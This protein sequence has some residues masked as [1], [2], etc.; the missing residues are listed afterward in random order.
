MK[1]TVLLLL[2]GG[3]ILQGLEAQHDNQEFSKDSISRKVFSYVKSFNKRESFPYYGVFNGP[4]YIGPVGSDFFEFRDLA[5]ID[6]LKHIIKHP[7]PI[8]K[9]YAF[10][11]LTHKGGVDLLPIIHEYLMD[12]THL[13][14]YYQIN[15]YVDRDYL[16]C[17]FFIE[18]ATLYNPDLTTEKRQVYDEALVSFDF[19]YSGLSKDQLKELDS[20]LIFTPNQLA[21]SQQAFI[22]LEA[23][24]DFY[25]QLKIK[26][27]TDS[28]KQALVAIAKFRKQQDIK[29][30]QEEPNPLIKLSAIQAFP[31]T[32]FIPYLEQYGRS[33]PE[34]KDV[35]SADHIY[36]QTLT[37][38]EDDRILELLQELM[39]NNS[40]WSHKR[41][42]YSF[43]SKS[44]NLSYADLYLAFYQ[45][46][47][48][49]NIDVFVF[50]CQNG[51]MDCRQK[52]KT[53]LWDAGNTYHE[54]DIAKTNHEFP[55]SC[56]RDND[57]EIHI[58]TEL[59]LAI[60][61]TIGKEVVLNNLTVGSSS[62]FE[63]F[64]QMAARIKDPDMA[65]I[66][67]TRMSHSDN[68][69][70][71]DDCL[72]A[73]LQFGMEE[74]S[75]QTISIIRKKKEQLKEWELKR[76]RATFRK[77]NIVWE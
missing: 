39:S 37:L 6:E 30:I 60:D 62:V 71:M 28:I 38:Y 52:L 75:Q 41:T 33:I 4:G 74:I 27:Q 35:T 68:G 58:L 46:F 36:Y 9:A 32:F 22:H 18:K 15:P 44:L 48:F 76:L 63:V 1:K 57:C 26:Y 50:L 43:I 53:D 56:Y 65:D 14:G 47:G 11:S 16:L 19:T 8:V 64:A 3:V 31:D 20:L 69:S 25:E 77:H 70:E 40:N 34:K 5:T 10:W 72:D 23:N 49:M 54:T 67:L 73:L 21:H 45:E 51:M 66:I 61:S 7:N 12:T 13:E 42:I 55:S 59:L 2:L 24:P 17:D 29:L